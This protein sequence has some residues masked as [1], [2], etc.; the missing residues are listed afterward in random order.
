MIRGARSE[1]STA[2]AGIY[3]EGIAERRSTFETEP[4]SAADIEEWL[5]PPGYPVLVAEQRGTVV[6]WARIAAYSPRPCYAGI[7][8]GS[9]YVRASQR[10]QGLGHAL[11]TALRDAA[12]HAGFHKIVG[13]LFSDNDASRRLVARHGFREVGTH[14]R[15]GEINGDW[16]DVIVVELLLD[17]AE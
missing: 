1:A 15:H 3:N 16:R 2:I 7:G 14:L 5:D 13:K 9:V 12:E 17:L 11:A 4:R 6:G 10:G 8:E